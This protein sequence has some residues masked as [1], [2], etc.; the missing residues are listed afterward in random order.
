MI[1]RQRASSAPG[2]A[3]RLESW[4]ACSLT[5]RP[6]AFAVSNTRAICSGEKAMPS[7]KPST[8]SARASGDRGIMLVGDQID[9]V[10][11]S[12]FEFRRQRMRAEEA[13]VR[14]VTFARFASRRATRS[15]FALVLDVEPVAGLD[16]DG[17]DPFRRSAHRGAAGTGRRARPRLRRAGARPSRRCR[18]RRARSPH[19]LRPR[20]ASRT[21]WRG[22]RQ[23]EMGVAVDQAGRDQPAF[24]ID[25]PGPSQQLGREAGLG[26]RH[27]QYARRVRPRR[28]PKSSRCRRPPT[29]SLAGHCARQ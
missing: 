22:R 11:L 28:L 27:R 17:R 25:G 10:V 14:T 6:R 24:A 19:R 21:R 18:R 12:P 5:G 16:L 4:S 9:I 26:S 15:D 29:W 20:A 13:C 3:G 1:G 8:A 23:D 7:Q 2:R